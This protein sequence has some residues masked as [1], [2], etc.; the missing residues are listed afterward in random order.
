M[1][2]PGM[3][4]RLTRGA[5]TVG[6]AGD[7]LY[8]GHDHVTGLQELQGDLRSQLEQSNILL[9]PVS[10]PSAHQDPPRTLSEMLRRVRSGAAGLNINL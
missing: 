7:H 4:R 1:I 3:L 9:P 2:T 5:D 8:Y 10:T 6:E